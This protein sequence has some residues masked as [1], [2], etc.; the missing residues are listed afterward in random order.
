[1]PLPPPL[2]APY[3]QLETVLNLG[4]VRMNDAIQSIGGDILT[5]SQPFTA[6]MVTGAWRAFQEYLANMGSVRFKKPLILYAFPVVATTDPAAWTSL[7]WTSFFD[8]VSNWVPPQCSVLPQDFICPLKMWERQ[9]GT[10]SQ[11]DLSPMEQAVEQLPDARKGAFNGY[12][13]WENDTLYMPGSLY[14]MDL[15][16]E[17]AAYLADF[18]VNSDGSVIGN[19]P[20]PIMRALNP[21]AWYF[22][23]EAAEGRDDVDKDAFVA[24]AEKACRSLFNRE[25]GMKQRRA[26]SRRGFSG[27]RQNYGIW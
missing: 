16:F 9:T 5:D 23:A 18:A 22:C 17:Y 6:T 10:Q 25:V 27:R 13:Y 8:G 7:T 1:M 15:R 3:D 2:T 14:S 26:I 11:F 21:L 19:Q 4:R 20:V 12:W 24:K